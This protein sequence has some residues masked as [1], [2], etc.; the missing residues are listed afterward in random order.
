MTV[1]HHR[2]LP[3]GILTR[4]AAVALTAFPAAAQAGSCVATC[5]SATP[6]IGT[7]VAPKPFEPP[8]FDDN[9]GCTFAVTAFQDIACGQSVCGEVWIS[10][11]PFLPSRDIDW[12]KITV[13]AAGQLSWSVTAEFPVE[14]AII[15]DPLNPC[16]SDL[17]QLPAS[18]VV[19]GC[20]TTIATCVEP[21]VHYLTVAHVFAKKGDDP[22][23]VLCDDPDNDYV[24][25]VTCTP[26]SPQCL[27]SEC[28]ASAITLTHSLSQA[29]TPM[30]SVACTDGIFTFAQSYGRAFNLNSGATAGQPFALQCVEA[31]IERNTGAAINAEVRVYRDTNGGGPT[32]AGTD[33]VLLGSKQVLIPNGFEQDFI[34]ATFSP[35]LTPP[36]NATIFIELLL[37]A[38]VTGGVWPGAN[39]ASAGQT[40]PTYFKSST[41][42]FP[43]WV[44]L[45]TVPSC[46]ICSVQANVLNVHGGIVGACPEDIAGPGGGPSDGVVNGFDLAVL[47]GQ[48]T[49]AATYSPCPP[50]RSGDLAGAAGGPPDC[51]VNGFDLAVLLAGWGPC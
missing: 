7:C 27:G 20:T 41:C 50:L 35:P 51:R 28:G 5:G 4:C 30:F 11:T 45:A 9:G 8:P 34:A 12:Y 10:Q 31:A 49:G 23:F 16:E 47:L 37:P 26:G 3:T 36:V 22:F 2:P 21:G 17:F 40:G 39:A 33:L 1:T 18:P 15:S 44:N 6:E 38:S 42:S 43:G 13:A 14:L 32:G 19:A 48:W 25:T 29:I 46:P 24:A